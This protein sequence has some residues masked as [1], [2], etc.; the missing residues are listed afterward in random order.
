MKVEYERFF[1]G[2][3]DTPPEDLREA[4]RSEL[5][6]LRHGDL[7][8]VEAD[9]RLGGIE[10]RFNS[11]SEL[12]GRRLRQMEEGATAPALRGR[13]P[14]LDGERGLVVGADGVGEQVAAA[15][16]RTLERRSKTPPSFDVATFRNY[17][18]RQLDAL[19]VKTGCER[20]LFRIAAE[21][22]RTKLKAK[23]LPSSQP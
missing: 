19:R 7:K 9:F 14:R 15:L 1:N 21:G 23:P 3:L 18:E 4:I 6:A 8:S 13:Q 5:R 20:V 2:G 11:L 16:Y 22:G 17:L 12:L 10:A